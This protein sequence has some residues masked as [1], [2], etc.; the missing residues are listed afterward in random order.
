MSHTLRE[1]LLLIPSSGLDDFPEALPNDDSAQVLSGWLALWHPSLIAVTH[2]APRWQ[3]ANQPPHSFEG[4]LALAP[5]CTASHL[6]SDLVNTAANAGGWLVKPGKDWRQ[7][8]QEILST[9][10]IGTET[11]MLPQLQTEFAALGYAYLQIQLLTQKL[12]YTSNLD[13]LLFDTQVDQAAS[14]A[15]AG[16]VGQA[17]QLLQSC[18]DQLGQERDH[19]YSLDVSLLDVTLLAESTLGTAVA[20][21]L[22]RAHPTT[23]VGSAHLLRQMRSRH[24]EVADELQQAFRDRRASLAG[25]L[26]VERPHPL[27]T[28]D[29]LKRDLERGANAYRELGLTPPTVFTRF[30]FGQVSDMPLHL[31]RSGYVGSMLIA[32]QDGTYPSG[33]HAKFSWEAAEG[34]FLNAIAPPLVD[35]LSP[36]TYLTLGRRIA[37]ALD[38]QHV[39]VFMMAHWPNQY[40]EFFELLECVVRHTPALGRWQNVDDFF[41]KTDQPYHQEN[42]PGRKF[43]HDWASAAGTH[44]DDLIDRST[45][46]HQLSGEVRQLQNVVNL[47]YQL[48]N[49][50]RRP[51]SPEKADQSDP[52]RISEYVERGP[53]GI[54]LPALDNH[55]SQLTDQ[56][57]AIF[58]NS[59]STKNQLGRLASDL[60]Q[61]RH[62]INARFARAAGHRPSESLSPTSAATAY[63][64]SNPTSAPQRLV[65]RS[66]SSTGPAANG[67]WLYATGCDSQQR[68]SM[69]DLPAFGMLPV[70]M[71]AAPT[72]SRRREPTLVQGDGLLVNDFMELQIDSRTGALRSLHAPG[73]RGNRFSLQIARRERVGSEPEYSQMQLT[74]LRT[75]EN[76]PV[77][78]LIRATGTC[79]LRGER[80]AEFEIDYELLRGQR[81]L[82]VD[83][84]MQSLVA[85]SG[86]PWISGY[87]L[88]SAWPNEASVISTRSCASR[89]AFPSGKAIATE[90]I[91]IDEVEYRTYLLTAGL[92]F[93]QRVEQRFLETL[94]GSG[95]GGKLQRKFGIGIDLPNASV[96]AMQFEQSAHI[97][98][99][100]ATT[101]GAAS[102]PAWL[103]H[104]DAKNV[105]MQLES[106]LVDES[107]NCA[108]IRV[109]VSE[110]SG[111]SVTARIRTLREVREAHRVDYLGNRIAKLTVEGDTTSIAVRPHEMT[112]VDLEWAS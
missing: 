1:C 57:D 60:A 24:P 45:T 18:F 107:G 12:R 111:K 83:V 66:E 37:E 100:Q 52:N 31:R 26:D 10:S 86:S 105:L 29:T 43:W 72:A 77:R 54:S 96:S 87:V 22:G 50:H 27:M 48:E 109:H 49:F 76:S 101:S 33:S 62:Q 73:K 53:Q 70:T 41:E 36:S 79:L 6:P 94:L 95:T 103:M 68:L 71:Q 35:A 20:K 13:Q 93:H 2:A 23:F 99:L 112:L 92:P 56:V 80:T 58:D 97:V 110:L 51:N 91:E 81:V 5:D 61:L 75:I 85:L 17:Q 84:R 11:A 90:W 19:Y 8:Q 69:I 28:L 9:L 89:Q 25:G 63:L 106:P 98:P 44:L 47:A 40:S 104:M 59:N 39:P 88:R 30:S 15:L 4:I 55:L 64:L 38:H 42:L 32:W 78:G 7:L 82:R 34:T 108:G 74:A 14:A 16:D 21:Q 46:Y 65:H 3:S 67:N 102:D